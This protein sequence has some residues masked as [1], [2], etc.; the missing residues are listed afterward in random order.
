MPA[1]T[2]VFRRAARRSRGAAVLRAISLNRWL[3][4]ITS[5][6]ASS[7]QRSPT[8]PSA[9]A[10]EQGPSVAFMARRQD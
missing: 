10:A 8:S 1:A 5:R 4:N 9:A 2:R 7:A 3:P 6:T